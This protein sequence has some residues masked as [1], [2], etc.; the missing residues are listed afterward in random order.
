MYRLIHN[1]SF[2][3][4]FATLPTL[5]SQTSV[6]QIF[7][8]NAVLIN[9]SKNSLFEC[10]SSYLAFSSK[11]LLPESWDYIRNFRRGKKVI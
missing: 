2:W 11:F 10:A 6:I 3:N 1:N 8:L 7:S 4:F 5:R 9:I